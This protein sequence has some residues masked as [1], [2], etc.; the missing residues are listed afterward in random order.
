MLLPDHRPDTPLPDRALGLLKRAEAL[1]PKQPGA[2][3]YLGL[4]AVQH[5]DFATATDYWQRLLAVLPPEG[6]QHQAVAQAI[7]AIKGK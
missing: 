7:E 3:W 6:E 4:A 2:L 1:D 5:R